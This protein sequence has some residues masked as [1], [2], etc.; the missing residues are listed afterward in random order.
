MNIFLRHCNFHRVSSIRKHFSEFLRSLRFPRKK[1]LGNAFIIY[2]FYD[3][4]LRVYFKLY[5]W[6]FGRKWCFNCDPGSISITINYEHV[7]LCNNVTGGIFRF[8]AVEAN[9]FLVHPWMQ[10][11]AIFFKLRSFGRASMFELWNSAIYVMLSTSYFSNL[12][13]SVQPI[14]ELI[15][16]NDGT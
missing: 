16:T 7:K 2:L 15:S 8:R 9:S 3:N 1:L 12:F 10:L 4:E 6:N 13:K 5:R 11:P 14:P